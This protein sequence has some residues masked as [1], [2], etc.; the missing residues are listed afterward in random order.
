VTQSSCNSEVTILS[1]QC[2]VSLYSYGGYLVRNLAMNNMNPARDLHI[3]V[4]SRPSSR[5]F[6]KGG[7]GQN[8]QVHV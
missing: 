3:L 4:A 5:K 8:E 2:T 1:V 7:G 6:S